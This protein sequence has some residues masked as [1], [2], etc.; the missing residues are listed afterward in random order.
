MLNIFC[1]TELV[2]SWNI[3]TN[4]TIAEICSFQIFSYQEMS[5]EAPRTDRW[6]KIGDVAALPLPM[7]CSLTKV[8]IMYL[9][10][11][12]NNFSKLN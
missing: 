1:F 7:S 8:N 10:N 9:K 5:S 12:I 3:A 4:N 2:L 6:R 11:K